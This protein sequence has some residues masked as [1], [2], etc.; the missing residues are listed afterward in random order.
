MVDFEVFC[1]TI[2]KNIILVIYLFIYV[3][4]VLHPDN[5]TKKQSQ[6]NKLLL[7]LSHNDNG[8]ESNI[9]HG[10]KRDMLTS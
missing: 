8:K 5:K 10:S 3:T 9:V 2:S 7:N 1:V 4:C 6:Q